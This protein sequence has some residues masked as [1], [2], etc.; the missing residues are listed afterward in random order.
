[1]R[2]ELIS[3]PTPMHPLGGAYYTAAGPSKGAVWMGW[4]ERSLKKVKPFRS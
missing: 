1:M 4:E 3:V 2:S